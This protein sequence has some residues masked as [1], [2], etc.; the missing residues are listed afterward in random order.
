MDYFMFETLAD[1]YR[2]IKESV[3]YDDA[4]ATA[5]FIEKYGLN[6]LP[7][8]VSKSVSIEKFPV[9]EEGYDWYKDNQDLYELYPLVAWYLEPP[10]A[11]AEFSFPAYK[12]GILLNKREYRTPEQW[13]VA[14]NKLLGAIALRQYEQT[15]GITGNNTDAAR[16]LRNAKK[17]ELEQT[18]WGYGQPS[19][20]GQPAQ[21][22][23]GMQVDQLIKMAQ[24]P[25]L[26]DNEVI[27]SLNKYLDKRQIIINEF[28]AAGMSETIWTSSSKYIG[29]RTMLRGYANQLIQENGNFGPLFDQLLAKELEP[30]YEDNLLLELKGGS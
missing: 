30:E 20:V 16:A 27:I 23:I 28:V 19:I 14:K 12:Q 18:Y 15:I 22:S 8:T 24:N 29:I 25:N 7:L 1:E 11:Y 5:I 3:N 2:T 10:P 9:T 6:P 26:Q 13:A 17:K 21:P 4:V